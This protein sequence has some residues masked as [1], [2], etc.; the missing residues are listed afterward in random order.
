MAINK[1][2]ENG[3]KKFNIKPYGPLA[4]IIVYCM[5]KDDRLP[6]HHEAHK[7][8][9]GGLALKLSDHSWPDS[10]THTMLVHVHEA[11]DTMHTCMCTRAKIKPLAKLSA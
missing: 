11:K 1:A 10:Q 7:G 6:C 2:P 8:S 3:I 5:A 4:M 9:E